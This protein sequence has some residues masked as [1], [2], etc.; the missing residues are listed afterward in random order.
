MIEGNDWLPDMIELP[1]SWP[2]ML[3]AVYLRF[4][5]DLVDTG[6]AFQGKRLALRKHPITDGREFGFWHCISEG[7][8]E[9]DRVPD[10]DRCRRIC[11]IRAVI[12][13]HTDPRVK[14]WVERRNEQV[15]HILW[16]NEEY[17]IVLGERSSDDQSTYFLLKTA[18]CTLRE[19]QKAKKR[20]AMEA[21]KKASTAP[22]GTVPNTP[23]THGG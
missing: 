5:N 23:S 22:C 7:A 14:Y 3:D 1:S 11:W 19:H 15:D 6:L 21:A 8:I 12:E 20:K 18:F 17:V 2:E 13:N 4:V 16:L 9:A 10:L